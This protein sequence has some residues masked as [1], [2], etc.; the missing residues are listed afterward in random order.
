MP[1][2]IH[3][4]KPIAT[5]IRLINKYNRKKGIELKVGDEDVKVEEL[6]IFFNSV[7]GIAKIIKSC[8]LT[9]DDVKVVCS[10]GK[11][12]KSNLPVPISSVT[13]PNKKIN[14]FT[15]KG[16]QGCNL[17]SNNGLVVV[18]SDS[19]AKHTLVDIETTM[20]QIN[21]R[22]RTNNEF[23][24]IFKDRMW[25]IYSTSRAAQTED[26]FQQ[27]LESIKNNT[28]TIL[29]DINAMSKAGRELMLSRTDLDDF[30]CAIED[31]KLIFEEEQLEYFKYKHYLNDLVYANGYTV[32]AQYDKACSNKAV[33]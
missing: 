22:L 32:I 24:N 9:E 26:E 16:F 25:H 4:S 31:N 3:S 23:N 27:E 18:I 30:F 5:A 10:E 33:Q 17:F 11:L 6:Y 7:R 14:M 2:R 1:T 29:K 28:E 13:S 21:G 8:D 15:K 20:Y 12:N 19:R